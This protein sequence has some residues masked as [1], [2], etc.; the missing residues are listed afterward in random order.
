MSVLNIFDNAAMVGTL[1]GA[2]IGGIGSIAGGIWGAKKNYDLIKK[3]RLEN[4]KAQEARN[5][6]MVCAYIDRANGFLEKAYSTHDQSFVCDDIPHPSEYMRLAVLDWGWNYYVENVGLTSNEVMDLK[7]WFI[8]VWEISRVVDTPPESY[9]N[10]ADDISICK[11]RE[12]LNV[13]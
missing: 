12:K 10:L 1:L 2:I 3:D 8:R 4:Q 13:K 11:I 6:A 9:K 7:N 5:K